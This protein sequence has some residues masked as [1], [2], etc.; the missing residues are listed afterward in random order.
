MLEGDSL[1]SR[2]LTTFEH[3]YSITELE[4]LAVVWAFEG[5][6]NFVYGIQFEVIS[7]HKALTAI[8]K[9]NLANKTCSD[10]LTRWIDRLPPFQFTVT[11]SP[12]R[13][14]GMAVYLSRHRSPS[15]QNNQIKAE[16]LCNDWFTVYKTVCEKF[17]L[18][19]KKR[20]EAENQ[21]IREKTST[22]SK[23]AVKSKRTAGSESDRES[24]QCKQEKQTITNKIASINERE[25]QSKLD[26][27]SDS[28]TSENR[29]IAFADKAPTKTPVCDSIHQQVEVFHYLGNYTFAAQFEADDFE[30]NNW[31]NC[32]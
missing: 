7:D 14:I 5:F 2:F 28:D 16:E 6:R 17:V 10:R 15:N 9:G 23:M 26:S 32:H 4:L 19:E 29:T 12:G 1:L 13:T 30:K 24:T 8:L 22:E 3:K 21:P 27:N 11:H 25:S 20:R 31:S 18:D